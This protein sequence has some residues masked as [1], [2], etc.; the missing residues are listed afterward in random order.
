MG[1]KKKKDVSAG[2][3]LAGIAATVLGAA[4]TARERAMEEGINLALEDPAAARAWLILLRGK[5][6]QRREAV[7]ALSK[8]LREEAE[9]ARKES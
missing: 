7:S 9:A 3:A 8:A 6:R 5:R 1:K 4:A 2:V